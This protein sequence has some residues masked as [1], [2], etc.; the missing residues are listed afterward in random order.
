LSSAEKYRLK[1][2]LFRLVRNIFLL[3]LI[4]NSIT[5]LTSLFALCDFFVAP[6]GKNKIFLKE[7][8]K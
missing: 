7:K 5:R 4:R 6:K 2:A 8:T 3:A 1:H